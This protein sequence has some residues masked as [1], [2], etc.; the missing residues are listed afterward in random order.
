M[1]ELLP[2]AGHVKGKRSPVTCALKCGNA[3]IKATCNTSANGYFR[4]IVGAQLSRRAMLGVSAA[5]ALAVAVT[6]APSPSAQAAAAAGTAGGSL[7]FT[8]IDPVQHEVDKF[9]VPDGYSWHPIVRWGDPLFPDAP[10][11]DPENQ[12]VEAQRRQF[13]YNNDYLSI[14][15][16]ED[17]DGNTAILFA[18]Q[19][20]TNDA[21]MYPESMDAATQREIS[22]N[23]HGLTVIDLVRDDEKSPWKVDV[24]GKHN[25]RFLIDTEYAFTGPA[26]GSDLLRTKDYPNGDKAQGTLGN[27]SGGLTP[28]GTLL[29]GEENFNSYF[30]APGTSAADKRYGLAD[31]ESANGWEADEDRFD[32]N[33]AGYANEANRFGWIVE[34]DPRNPDSTPRKH[35]NMGRL[36]HEGAN[37]RIAESGQAVAY[38]GDD[39]KFDYLYKFV[40]KGK[41]VEGD[42]DHNLTLL[43]EGDLFVAKFT[44]NSPK[45]EIDGS[46]AVPSDGEFDGSGKWLPLIKGGKS[47]VAGMSVAE[48]LVHTRLAADK[49]GPTKMD[50]CEDVEPNPVNGKIYVACTNNDARGTEGKAG[51]DE[52]NPRTENRDGHIVE[53]TERGG[54]HTGTEFD[55]TLL[56]VCGDPKQ[57]DQTYFSGFPVDQ[58]SPI[59][60]P[61]NVAFDSAGNLW[62]STDGAPDGIGYC[63]GLFKVTIDGDQRGRV[64]QFLSV[65]REA[66]VCGPL[67]HD[68]YASAFVAVQHPGEDGEW[69]DQHSQFPDYVDETDVD[70][71]KAALP[72]PTVVQ[73]IKGSGETP[74]DP[75]EDPDDKDADADGSD[76][77][78]G[79][80]ADK[81][82]SANE[83]GGDD[84]S[85]D[86]SSADSTGSKAGSQDGAKDAAAAGAA[87]NSDGSSSSGGSGSGGSGGSGSGSGGNASGGSGGGSNGGGSSSGG[88]DGGE[89]PWT[90]SDSTLPLL[91]G[92]AGLLAAGGAMATAA[93]MKRKKAGEAEG[94][95]DTQF[96]D[97]TTGE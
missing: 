33:N 45:D 67:V 15:V 68:S 1:R 87:S 76:G 89:L 28:W 19:E 46:G 65:P 21:I 88:S 50:R 6:T 34:V 85:K 9:I 91:G 70:G 60:C 96:E 51:V 25:R 62:I 59:S 72:R 3:C 78:D 93:H 48:V 14:Q 90:G 32:T 97:E 11:F 57:G 18:N 75:P 17:G 73:V 8:A 79:G 43:T 26:A 41:Y 39:E 30:R 47:Q 10:K 37:V 84:G 58:V 64:E 54:D 36:K 13:G 52:A 92:G 61:D 49:V 35:T 29:S 40:S 42:L 55:W 86:G 31:E 20:Y 7:D 27:C 77:A 95:A 12:S 81:D 38:M 74:T 4:D 71:G 56:M 63:D 2:M 83:S 22:R 44:G 23:A 5:G 24:N 69:S 94:G 80:S 16:D 66:E 82:G 53:I